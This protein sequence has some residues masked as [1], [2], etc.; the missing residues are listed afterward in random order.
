MTNTTQD[1]TNQTITEAIR[2]ARAHG[3]ELSRSDFKVYDG[4]P[5]LDGMHPFDWLAAMTMD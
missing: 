2:D 3:I 5:T 1:A 4:E